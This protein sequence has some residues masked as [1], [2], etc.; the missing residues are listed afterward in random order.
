MFT[1]RSFG[2][3]VV[4]GCRQNST[5][6]GHITGRVP[7]FAFG[8]GLEV[9]AALILVYSVPQPMVARGRPGTHRGRFRAA[10][11]H[12]AGDRKQSAPGWRMNLRPIPCVRS[13]W[14]QASSG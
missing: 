13:G 1:R 9:V 3:V 10:G 6:I 12:P 4:S 7:F 14:A 5:L 11:T 2:R 8:L